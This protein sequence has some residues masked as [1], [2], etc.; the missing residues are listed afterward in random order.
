MID[1]QE[2]IYPLYFSIQFFKQHINVIFQHVLASTIEKLIAL[3][4][5]AYFRPPIIIRFH[6]L[7]AGDNRKVMGEITSSHKR[8]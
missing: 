5:D 8:D 7:H 3:V 6:N 2:V 1:D 4:G